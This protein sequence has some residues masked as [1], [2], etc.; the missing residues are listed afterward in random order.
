MRRV[1][2]TG[3]AGFLGRHL[4]AAVRASGA[5]PRGLDLAEGTPEGVET[6]RGSLDDD[7]LLARALDG[8]DA[9]IHAAA[10]A[11]LWR[12]DPAEF[13]A[14]NHQGARRL[15]RG[16]LA[17]GVRRVAHISS[18][19]TLIAGG[20]VDP[21][22]PLDETVEH[23]PGALLGPYPAAKRRAELAAVAAAR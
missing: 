5:E 11:D 12:A 3:S 2:I 7:A 20:R 16:A 9:V 19:T 17:A 18:Y 14:V 21:G 22:A 10:L 4:C 6:L 15:F 1:L 23:P 13:D 8:V